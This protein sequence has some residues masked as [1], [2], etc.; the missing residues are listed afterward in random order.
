MYFN[1]FTFHLLTRRVLI[2]YRS[3][4]KAVKGTGSCSRP[5]LGKGDGGSW[6]RAHG[7]AQHGEDDRF[8][9][10][11]H[12]RKWVHKPENTENGSVAIGGGAGSRNLGE[13]LGAWLPPWLCGVRRGM[14]GAFIHRITFGPVAARSW[15]LV[16]ASPSGCCVSPTASRRPLGSREAAP[17]PHS[18]GINAWEN[19]PME[20]VSPRFSW[21]QGQ[22]VTVPGGAPGVVFIVPWADFIGGFW[23]EML[24]HG[25]GYA[26]REALVHALLLLPSKKHVQP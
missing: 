22:C 25:E 24:M 26:S 19:A 10:P 16:Q 15:G 23:A 20:L 5:G 1:V 21:D 9:H 2:R 7:R 4:G 17:S 6:G 14:A 12:A 18:P 3:L 11:V 13:E 8:L